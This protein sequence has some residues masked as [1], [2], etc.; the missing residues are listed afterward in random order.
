MALGIGTGLILS[1]VSGYSDSS[2]APVVAL[3]L[4][5]LNLAI[6]PDGIF[7]HNKSRSV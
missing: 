6:K 1:V 5:A 7:G 4:L 3:V 2:N